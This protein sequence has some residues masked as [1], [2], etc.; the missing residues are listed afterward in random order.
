LNPHVAF[1][2]Q[3]ALI[4]GTARLFGEVL[5]RANQ[6]PVLGELMAGIVLGPSLFGWLFPGAFHSIFGTPGLP[7]TDVASAIH[8]QAALN[9]VAGVGL[10]LLMLLTGLETDIRIMRNMGR[11]AFTASI[12]GMLIP[13]G[14]GLLL[15]VYLDDSYVTTHGREVL[16]LFLATAM[17]ISAM[18]VIAKILLDLN[19]MKRNFGVVILSAAVVD[20]TIGWI[21]L[22]IITSLVTT[23]GF[24]FRQLAT[25]VLL[26]A[27]FIAASRYVLFPL[28]KRA[29]NSAH[30]ELRMPNGELVIIVVVAFLCAAATEAMH[31]H[32][33]FGA[34][35]AGVIFR[36][37][38]GL[39]TENLHQLESV[40]MAL[41]APLFFGSVGLRVDLTQ[42]SSINL[43]LTVIVIAILGK[44]I[45]CFIGGIIGRMPAWEALGVGLGMSARGAME[46][47]VAKIGLDLGILNQELFSAIVLMAIVTS[48][49]APVTLKLIAPKLPMSEEEKLREKGSA[50]GFVPSGNLKVLI[51]AGGGE[52][53]LVGTHIGSHLCRSEGDRATAL[54]VESNPLSWWKRIIS[55][56]RRNTDTEAYFKRLK[57]AAGT[58][59]NR[60][61]PRKI[62]GNES[63]LATIMTEAARGYQFL[64]IGAAGQR[65]PLYDP[66]ISDVVRQA[67]CHL[68]VVAGAREAAG[69]SLPFKN[70]L[71]PTNGSY[72][73]DAAFEFAAH[74]ANTTRSNVTV[75]YIAES[76]QRN[77]LLPAAAV[78]EVSDYAQEMM[79]V[80]LK[81]QFSEKLNEPKNL[82]CHVRES[83]SVVSALVAEVSKGD[84]DLVVLGAENKSLVE[85]LYLGQH[86]EAAMT[87]VPCTIALV[88]PKVGRR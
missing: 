30:H 21:I 84:Y 22:A 27:I 70:I 46:L 31:V 5:R 9:H 29:I 43:P 40:T 45:G 26:L 86:I 36:Q 64:I 2:L 49:L 7:A 80:T 75:L 50:G 17:A 77:P 32:A 16:T 20:D 63:V 69:V 65:H 8:Y 73:S 51:P 78:S 15:G 62:G 66:F 59:A 79:R 19:M 42:L 10:I 72:F 28:V 88:I 83:S 24:E 82:E 47:V 54:Y 34:F 4:L 6:P 60:L 61:I 23:G 18:P 53:A 52:N 1:L 33:V 58:F 87:E 14:S 71:V 74:Y 25:T 67:P 41:F 11:A 13:F 35:V 39:S 56:R 37:C 81:Q 57:D 68:V 48:I 3:I 55:A 85:R 76:R 44:V 12:F 38:P